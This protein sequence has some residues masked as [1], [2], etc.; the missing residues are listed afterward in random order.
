MLQWQPTR[1]DWWATAIQFVGTL[2]FNASTFAALRETFL[3]GTPGN[4]VWVPDLLGSVCFLLASA[5]AWGEAGDAWWSWRPR[6]LGWWIAAANLF[7][8]IAFGGSAI[9][10]YTN[11]TTG[12]VANIQLATLGT[13]VGAICFLAGATLLLPE[14]TAEPS[15]PA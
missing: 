10:A 8:S 11:P 3:F 4:R 14:R 1:I 15:A 13:F 5:L 6:S 12:E 9:G 7:G 2:L